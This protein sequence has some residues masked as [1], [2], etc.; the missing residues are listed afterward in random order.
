MPSRTRE[1]LIDVARQLFA[2]QGI[3]NTTMN[4]IATASDRGRRT[5][6]TYFR[7]KGEIYQAVIETE[8]E[9]IR[10]QLEATVAAASTPREKL[11]ALMEYR[12]ALA[13]ENNH[14]SEV[15]LRSLFSRDVKRA[16][17]VRA[18]VTDRI[19]EMIDEIVTDGVRT[20]AFVREQAERVP[21]MLTMLVRGTDWTLMRETASEQFDGWRRQCID[22]ILD[23][24]DPHSKE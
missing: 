10:K 12:L 24:L 7:T 20:G 5:V 8:S 22:F 16:N 13:A 2:R 23:A 15:W 3:E 11:K 1:R 14:G 18:M 17:K 4:D 19:Y 9:R 21:A 6:Y